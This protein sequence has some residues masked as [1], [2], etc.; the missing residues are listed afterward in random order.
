MSALDVVKATWAS[1]EARDT[2]AVVEHLRPDVVHD[3]SH[4]EGWPGEGRH[5]GVGHALASL[6]DWMT[7]WQGY[8]QD[9]VGFEEAGDRVL[10]LLRHTGIRDGERVDEDLAILFYV[11]DDD[12][13]IA[14]EP[15]SDVEAARAVLHG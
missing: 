14:W 12:R 13:I 2:E 3:L 7:W 8:R 1:W 6:G 10:A 5:V 4:Y 9:L 15:W 11:G